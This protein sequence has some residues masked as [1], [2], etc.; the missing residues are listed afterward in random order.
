[1]CMQIINKKQSPLEYALKNYTCECD[2]ILENPGLQKL[3]ERCFNFEYT[4]RPS[5]EAV[6]NDDFFIGYTVRD[7]WFWMDE[8]IFARINKNK[9]NKYTTQFY[10]IF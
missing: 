5:A 1:M 3:L 8:K 10:N 7:N 9:Y 2:L 4:L 6:Y